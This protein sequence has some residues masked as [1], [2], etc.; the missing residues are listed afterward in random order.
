[1]LD[2]RTLS[3]ATLACA[4]GFMITMW[5][6]R[7]LVPR[8]TSLRHWSHAATALCAGVLLQ[9]LRGQ[10]PEVLTIVTGNALIALGAMWCWTGAAALA[11]RHVNPQW[12]WG[13]AGVTWVGTWVMQHLDN[14]VHGR[15]ILLSALAATA[16]AGAAWGFW[17]V[18]QQRIQRTC[19]A[20]AVVF[21][22]GAL[23]FATRAVLADPETLRTPATANTSWEFVLPYAFAILFFNWVSVV[24]TVV[25]G[26]KLL[27]QL[28][29][30]LR[31]AEDSD[32][33]KSTFLSSITHE[34]RTPLNAIS[35]FSQ[36]M[37]LDGK[38]PE[39][40]RR[41]AAM[42]HTAGSQL[43]GVVNDLM[44][45]RQLQ[46][47]TLELKFQISHVQ[48]LVDQA[49][50]AHRE[51][52][53]MQHTGLTVNSAA[54]NPTVW[55]DPHRFKQA[56]GQLL[57]NA[58]KFN[59]AGGSTKVIWESDGHSIVVR[60]CDDGPG[61]PKEL[62]PRLFKPFDRLGI[63]SGDIPGVG[64]GLSICQLL[65]RRM[66]GTVGFASEQGKGA[67][68]WMRFP[69]AE[70]VQ[71]EV[72]LQTPPVHRVGV[73]EALTTL[74]NSS[75]PPSIPYGKRV[76]YVEDNV[77]NQKLVQAVFQKQLGLSV[78]V[79]LTAEEGLAMARAMLPSLILMDLNLPGMDGYQALKALRTDE[80]T[81][82][83]PVMA[84]TAQSRPADVERGQ[85]AGFDAYVTKP[86][87]LGSLITHA[88]RLLKG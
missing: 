27:E 59:S 87:N 42:I 63:E 65:V 30:A 25:V 29:T 15:L 20:T 2:L 28:R 56:L 17:M 74:P 53:Q 55:V 14:P 40:S 52:A 50:A 73:D 13:A 54:A 22:V 33:V 10:A 62:H 47:G 24:I 67:E 70:Q 85:E 1:M 3:V 18:G 80:Q 57:S 11:E 76:L 32:R 66:G 45:L 78:A 6:M 79:A 69:L 58:I 61:I 46:E 8:D 84:V 34:W 88:T 31:R 39:D 48:P 9:A 19:R 86:L 64:I 7:R 21:T 41:S 38:I 35:G 77:T 12:A 51:L 44:D 81:R 43:L 4:V 23:I 72:V 16:F 75:V 36:L 68:F 71:G 37:S 26:D 5:L 49:V 83:I 82:H 60:V